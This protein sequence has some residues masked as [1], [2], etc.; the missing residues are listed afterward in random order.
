MTEHVI[1]FTQCLNG[2]EIAIRCSCGFET[3]G[4]NKTDAQ[5]VANIHV[6]GERL[7]EAPDADHQG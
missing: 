6:L 5:R 3:V 4:H 2:R 7:K 1:T